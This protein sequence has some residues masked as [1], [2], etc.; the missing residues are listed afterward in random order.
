MLNTGKSGMLT[1]QYDLDVIAHN[2]ANVNTNGYKSTKTSFRDLMF[3]SMDIN[4]N[5]GKAPLDQ[6]L[7]GRGVRALGQDMLYSQ[8][9]ITASEYQLDYA[10]AGE[11]LFAVDY[12][13]NTM[14][15]RNGNFSMSVEQDG[16]YLVTNDGAH[17]LDWF[18]ERIK[19]PFKETEAVY[20]ENGNIT[21]FPQE[22]TTVDLEALDPQIGMFVFDNPSG[23][24]RRDSCRFIPTDVSGE[25]R[26][27]TVG[28]AG[29]DNELLGR[30]LERSNVGM[31]KE[32]SDLILSQ[33]AYQFNAR[34]VTTADQIEDEVNKLRG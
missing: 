9:V 15:T 14:Y 13:G 5:R 10:I 20:D 34:V 11:A 24:M 29:Y 25:A 21:Q 3:S 23:L 17:V 26:I 33:R 16:V 27:A 6:V 12:K 30:Y 8:G 18:G 31:A 4:K 2:I 32:M 7:T 22:T 19:I 28:T 1:Y